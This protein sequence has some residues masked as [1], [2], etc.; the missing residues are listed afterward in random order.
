V[1]RAHYIPHPA[2]RALAKLG[3]DISAARR[4]QHIPMEIMADR[5]GVSR[6]TLARVERGD[7]T[8][9]IGIYTMVLSILGMLHRVLHLADASADV[10]GAELA[11]EALP[12]R[13]RLPRV[14]P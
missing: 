2:A 12:K 4:R 6:S 13:V 8:V 11:D 7:A 3:R 10:I 14:K 1:K 5:V 9:A